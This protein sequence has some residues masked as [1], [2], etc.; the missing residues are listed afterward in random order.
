MIRP[1]GI[2][3]SRSVLIQLLQQIER[4]WLVFWDKCPRSTV[5]RFHKTSFRRFTVKK[6][7]AGKYII[8]RVK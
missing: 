6:G 7:L 3:D 8:E 5:S 4:G 2:H 1:V